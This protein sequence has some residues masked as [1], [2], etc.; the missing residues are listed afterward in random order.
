M[1]ILNSTENSKFPFSLCLLYIRLLM[2]SKN[3]FQL[4]DQT[5]ILLKTYIQKIQSRKCK[6]IEF[7]PPEVLQTMTDFV[8][9]D[10][11]RTPEQL[12]EDMQHVFDYSVATQHPR[13]FNQLYAWVH[14]YS[15][16]AEW[17]TAVLNTSMY[18]YEVAPLF[19]LMEEYVYGHIA[20]LLWWK[21]WY[22][23][24]MLPWWSQANLMAMHLARYAHNPLIHDDGLYVSKPLV[25]LTSDESHYSITKSAMLMWLWKKVS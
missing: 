22:D 15:I 7:F 21:I 17:I 9:S 18:T 25:V 14:P 6:V 8:I 11:W 20:Q 4:I 1:K 19:T 5:V 23:G 2:N 12:L 16:L 3:T 24:M 13:F 10:S